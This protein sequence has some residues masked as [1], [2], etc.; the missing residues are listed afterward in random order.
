MKASDKISKDITAVMLFVPQEVADDLLANLRAGGWQDRTGKARKGL[1]V[2]SEESNGV[3]RVFGGHT[4]DY[5]GYLDHNIPVV[6]AAIHTASQD[7]KRRII[8]VLNS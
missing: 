3:I 2:G 6:E 8:K 4:V 1:A 7:L 5:G